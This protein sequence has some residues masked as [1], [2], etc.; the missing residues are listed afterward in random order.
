MTTL[1]SRSATEPTGSLTSSSRRR[2]RRSFTGKTLARP[3]ERSLL[4]VP[5][6]GK[7]LP[8][9]CCRAGMSRA[10]TIHPQGRE[11]TSDPGGIAVHAERQH[12]VPPGSAGVRR[13][14]LADVARVPGDRR[15]HAL[16]E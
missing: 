2:M 1:G 8:N 7:A 6:A 14:G 15:V 4:H 3:M 10:P 9:R 11:T 13:F 5:F 16:V 12:A